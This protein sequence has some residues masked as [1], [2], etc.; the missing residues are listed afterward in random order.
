MPSPYQLS[1]EEIDLGRV[2]GGM[3]GGDTSRFGRLDETRRSEVCR[4]DRVLTTMS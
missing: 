2:G 3:D 1:D 4:F